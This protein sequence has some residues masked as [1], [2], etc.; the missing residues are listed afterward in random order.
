[1]DCLTKRVLVTGSS[2]F[3]GHHLV[4]YLLDH[5]YEVVGLDSLNRCG[6]SQ[7]LV[8]L[9]H[10]NYTN[11]LHDLRVPLTDALLHKVGKVDTVFSVASDSS[12]ATSVS[13]P[14]DVVTNNV[15]LVLN[16]LEACRKLRPNK[17]VHLSTDEVYGEV[18]G[19]QLHKESWTY[20]PSNP[21]SASK[22]CQ[23]NVL[24]AYWR[25]YGVPLVLVHCMNMFGVR[26]NH[27][28]MVPKTI[29]YLS[30]GKTVQVYVSRGKVGSRVYLDC[31]NLA[32]ALH[33][34]D[35]HVTPRTFSNSDELETPHKF[36][37]AGSEPLSNLELVKKV[38]QVMNLSVYH[39]DTVES[40]N[41]RPGYDRSYG[42]DDSLLRSLGWVPPYSL[43][44]G[45]RHTVTW[46]LNNK[47]WLA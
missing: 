45:L 29:K 3:V 30:E 16:L 21:Y 40:A 35:T 47:E 25:T 44:E 23:D 24:Y 43:E 20:Y 28:K 19:G 15:Q 37:V 6:D 31:R 14:V 34:V 12:V 46:S 36:N 27:E 11:V 26:Q 22:A 39:V 17:F 2:G 1:M 9:G 33:F 7:R 32:S 5:N 41:V 42:L 8:F 13:N 18:Y 38:A 10:K 4:Q